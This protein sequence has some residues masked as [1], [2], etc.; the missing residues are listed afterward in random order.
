MGVY[1]VT[2][3]LKKPGQD[4]PELLKAIRAYKHCHALKSAFFIDTAKDTS[5]VL[6][7]LKQHIDDTDMLYVMELK[8]DWTASRRS[9]GTDWL[10][11][12][13]RTWASS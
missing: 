3:D 9:S 8:Q 11:D 4:Y 13:S 6:E 12:G 2:Y 1:I 5:T 10:L 7:D